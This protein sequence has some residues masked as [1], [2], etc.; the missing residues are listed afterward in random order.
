MIDGINLFFPV[1]SKPLIAKEG[2]DV[3]PSGTGLPARLLLPILQHIRAD[4]A[5]VREAIADV[6]MRMVGGSLLVVYEADWERVEEGLKFL[7][8][9]DEDEMK[10]PGPPYIVQVIDFA[11]SHIVPGEGPDEGVLKGIDTTLDLLNQ[12]IHQV[13]TP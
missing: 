7:I 2:T 6:H 5:E 12:H 1:A 13:Q 4:I 9:D 3:Q 8:E 10:R 11:H